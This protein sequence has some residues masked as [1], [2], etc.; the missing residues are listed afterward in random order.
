[1]IIYEK[2]DATLKD[3]SHNHMDVSGQGEVIVQE[4]DGLP[5]KIKY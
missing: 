4:D 3:G 2:G 5:L 1:M